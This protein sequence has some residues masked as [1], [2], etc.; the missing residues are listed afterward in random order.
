MTSR[1]LV[2]EIQRKGEVI[3]FS[4][5]ALVPATTLYR[6]RNAQNSARMM[7]DLAMMLNELNDE[8][9]VGVHSMW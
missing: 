3:I 7:E 6:E 5:S 2:S 1:I 8:G 9:G 4:P